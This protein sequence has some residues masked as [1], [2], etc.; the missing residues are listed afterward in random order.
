MKLKIA[1]E[2]MRDHL[3]DL[4][5]TKIIGLIGVAGTGKS[6][7]YHSVVNSFYPAMSDGE[8]PCIYVPAP[9]YG[10]KKTSINGVIRD[11]LREVGDIC[12]DGKR[13]IQESDGYMSIMRHRLDGQRDAFRRMAIQRNVRVLAIDEFIHMIR[14]TDP[15]PLMDSIKG[16]ADQLNGCVMLIGG[17]S[18]F[19]YLT[20]DDQISRRSEHIYLGRYTR[21]EES[22]AKA[23][24]ESARSENGK[25][26]EFAPFEE[27][28]RK[29]MSRWPLEE[30]PQF[31][32]IMS[33]I[34]SCTLG[35]V[36]LLKML[37]FRCLQQQ[38]KNG[39]VWD[40]AFFEKSSKSKAY[41]D[42]IEEEVVAGEQR[43]LEEGFGIKVFDQKAR[44]NIKMKLKGAHAV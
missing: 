15:K 29:F 21:E 39:G 13:V 25:K 43:M 40:P 44:E 14:H 18:L 35:I 3:E 23:K 2:E 30:V 22:L 24:I 36:G 37:L 1:S 28:V 34:F 32:Q 38:L 6:T 31:H 41:I 26:T 12:I 16:V 42:S 5:D 17:I 9:A 19:S 4:Q 10:D 11:V 8:I 27:I 7:F 33:E 20:V